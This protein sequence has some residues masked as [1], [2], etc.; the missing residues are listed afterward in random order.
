MCKCAHMVIQYYT[1]PADKR[2]WL[3]LAYNNRSSPG[4]MALTIA[5]HSFSKEI[6]PLVCDSLG[7]FHKRSYFVHLVSECGV[8]TAL[9]RL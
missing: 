9:V 1:I 6:V 4:C 8:V 2:V 7:A 5:I 3:V